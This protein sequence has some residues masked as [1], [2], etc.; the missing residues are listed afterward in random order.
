MAGVFNIFVMMILAG[1]CTLKPYSAAIIPIYCLVVF[2]GASKRIP[3]AE[4]K[5]SDTLMQNERVL[6]KAVQS[7]PFSFF[8]RRQLVAITNSRIILISRGL[9]GGFTMK[10]FQWKD[11]QDA[12]ISENVLPKYCGSNLN[13]HTLNNKNISI[14]GVPSET[15]NAIYSVAQAEEQAWEEKIRIRTL[16]ET[17]AAAGGVFVH[18]GNPNNGSSNN[19]TTSVTEEIEKAKRLLDSGAISDSEFQEIKSKILSKNF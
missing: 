14:S 18:S 12:T 8:S 13:F 19:S 4:K 16:E 10:D 6:Q 7:R 15:A 1:L 3:K 5:L 2:V 17:R 11:L 9:F